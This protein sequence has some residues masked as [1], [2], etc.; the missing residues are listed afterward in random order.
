MLFWI[1][2]SITA[3][4]V[5]VRYGGESVQKVYGQMPQAEVDQLLKE[6]WSRPLLYEAY[7]Q[8]KERPFTGKYVNVHEQGFRLSKEQGPWPPQS[9][10][11][12]IFLFGGSTTFGYG[13]SD[14]QTIASYLQQYL[15]GKLQRPVCV[16]NFGRGFYYSTQELI[17]YE[18]LLI[19]GFVPDIA[20]FIDGV[21]D[22]YHYNDEPLFTERLQVFIRGDKKE[23]ESKLAVISK[24]PMARFARIILRIL[25]PLPVD[26]T[27]ITIA[28]TNL[29][30]Q[31]YDNQPLLEAVIDRYLQNKKLIEA[32]SDVFSVEPVFVW[33][34]VPTYDYD[35]H[36]Y[37][38]IEGGFDRHTYSKYGYEIMASRFDK[39]AFG[40]NFLWCADIQ[41]DIE[42]PL[43]IDKFHYSPPMSN[44][45]AERIMILMI[46]RKLLPDMLG[47]FD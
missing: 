13:V 35:F 27:T 42:E 24:L 44:L 25:H 18:R 6:T 40:N 19:S 8:F 38:F 33:Q 22:F 36:N 29:F 10:N 31:S 21:N 20:I 16:Y 45:F 17:L 11:L 43:Y 4:P 2:D 26:T 32:V 5:T 7:T 41:K 1:K 37:P 12:N 14:E 34:P 39:E 28:T 30:P 3:D 15:V 9:A 23:P 47:T 46:E